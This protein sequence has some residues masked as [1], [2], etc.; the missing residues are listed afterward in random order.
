M[1]LQ[2]NTHEFAACQINICNT[3]DHNSTKLHFG[4]SISPHS[5]R[6][7]L[8]LD[9]V[10]SFWLSVGVL[11]TRVPRLACLRPMAWLHRRPGTAHLQHLQDQTLARRTTARP[12]EGA[13]TPGLLLR[14]G[15]SYA[16]AQLHEVA[17][18]QAMTTNARRAQ[19]SRFPLWC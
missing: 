7:L 6:A 17:V 1:F 8:E 19:R 4:A 10:K 15:V 12:P 13:A 5:L 3:G 18:T 14:S 11:R 2:Q 9:G 16:S